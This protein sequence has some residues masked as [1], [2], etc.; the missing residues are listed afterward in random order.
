[1]K[2]VELPVR[3]REALGSANARRIRRD[4]GIPL[5]LYGGDRAPVTLTTTQDDFN[6]VLKAHSAIVRLTHDEV[7]QTAL[8]RDVAWD[9]FGDHVE[10][11]DLFRVE[12]EDEVKVKVPFHFVGVPRGQSNGGETMIAL[13]DIEVFSPVKDIPE[14]LRCDISELEVGQGIRVD[15]FTFPEGIRPAAHEH[16][17]IVQCKAPKLAEEEGEGEGDETAEGAEAPAAEG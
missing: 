6:E 11:V 3:P 12:L 13:Q 2:I 4:G 9:V 16:D 15:E 1:M 8:V 7:K 17:L 10:H 5:N 14:E